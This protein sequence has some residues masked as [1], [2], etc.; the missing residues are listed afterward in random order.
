M[1]IAHYKIG[2][3]IICLFIGLFFIYIFFEYI[4]KIKNKYIRM[5]PMYK[6]PL[7]GKKVLF[8]KDN[9][10]PIN[11]DG[12]HGHLIEIGITTYMPNFYAKYVKR[13]IDK[14]LAFIA[15]V[16]LS[17]LFLIIALAIKL[18]DPGPVLFTQ[19]RLGQNKTYFKLHKF[20]SMKMSTPHDVPTHMLQNPDQYITKIGKFIRLHSLDEL[21]QIWDIF[22]GNM[23]IIG[24]RPGLWNQDVLT[25]ERD[26]Y[27]VNDVKPGLTGWAQIN[28]R[29]ELSI[30]EKALLDGEYVNAL[31]KNSMCAFLMDLKCFFGSIRVFKG[32][33]SI[34]EGT[35]Q[36]V[37][38]IC[39]DKSSNK[40]TIPLIKKYILI[41]GAN[42][43]I[44]NNIKEYLETNFA[45]YYK[46]DVLSTK[47]LDPIPSMFENY[48]VV[49]NV[50]GIAHIKENSQNK[51]NYYTINRDLVI[52]IAK[53]AKIAGVK[54]FIMLSSMAVY[55]KITGHITLETAA[56]PLN[57]Y[58]DS[59][60]QADIAISKMANSNFKVAILRPPMVYGKGCKG[61]YQ[62]LRAFALKSPFFPKFP[63]KRSMIYIGN[64][65]EF[66]RRTID[67]EYNG[68]FF[69]QNAEYV[70]TS[71]M[72]RLIAQAHSK[73]IYES[74]V[75]N[76]FIFLLQFGV[77]KKVFGTLTY[78]GRDS[79]DTF[80]FEE[81]IKLTELS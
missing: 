63:N 40:S 67:L 49:I 15:L 59:K 25:A 36:S 60:N 53:N 24:P 42:S 17:P 16:L 4:A 20:R 7:E 10:D 68:I 57:A 31:M 32:D 8:I 69:P 79:I 22:V 50:A 2:L 29:D 73:K 26:K 62:L 45:T 51:K 78:E 9:I 38:K 77:I 64:L 6:N 37:L 35:K 43:Y 48:T 12:A 27:N 11:A 47:G 41:T 66:V 23:S 28:G 54:H 71:D 75:L 34:V 80:S 14:F 65:C 55:G 52:K 1:K 74:R 21:P 46:V 61:N 18:E 19:K 70:T 72:V 13:G 56:N 81:S 39:S 58:G 76:P 3:F 5:D 33:G 44:G 30:S